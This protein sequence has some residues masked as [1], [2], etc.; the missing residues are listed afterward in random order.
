MQRNKNFG[1]CIEF[2]YHT[3]KDL[4]EINVNSIE[5]WKFDSLFVNVNEKSFLQNYL[6]FLKDAKQASGEMGFDLYGVNF[7][8]EQQAKSIYA[9]IKQQPN[10]PGEM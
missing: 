8:T 1:E 9:Q 10:L 2:Q 3:K 5:H 7:Y 4:S 6:E